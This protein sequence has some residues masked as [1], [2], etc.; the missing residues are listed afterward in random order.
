MY[1]YINIT[2]PQA[3]AELFNS[4]FFYSFNCINTE[5]PND[6]QIYNDDNLTHTVL[7][8]EGVF[9]VLSDSDKSKA[10]GND[11]LPTIV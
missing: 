6:Y 2:D 7:T 1:N 3:K 5:P 11:G 4:F 9:K 10:M 8:E